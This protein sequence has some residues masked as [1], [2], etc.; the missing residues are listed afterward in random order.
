MR[1]YDVVISE[2]HH[3]GVVRRYTIRHIA[4]V[5]ARN[6]SS[7]LESDLSYH[8]VPRYSDSKFRLR[9]KQPLNDFKY[10]H[11]AGNPSQTSTVSVREDNA[12]K[13]RS[14]LAPVI[15]GLSKELRSCPSVH[16][17]CREVISYLNVCTNNL[18]HHQYEPTTWEHVKSLVNDRAHPRQDMVL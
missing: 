14:G 18:I 4:Y 11:D 16:H 3:S 2:L 13:E 5:N 1:L 17:V 8:F 6:S 7:I 9:T 15:L 12:Y 10:V